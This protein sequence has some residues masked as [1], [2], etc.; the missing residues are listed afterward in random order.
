MWLLILFAINIRIEI[1]AL[2]FVFGTRQAN[3]YWLKTEKLNVMM[4]NAKFKELEQEIQS[5]KIQ[6]SALKSALDFE[7][8]ENKQQHQSLLAAKETAE[9]N[10]AHLRTLLRTIPDLIWLKD[11]EGI[12]LHLNTRFEEFFGA[13][14]SQIL[15][16]TDYDF[17]AKNLGDFFRENDKKAMLAGK[18]TKNEEL[19]RFAS[20]GHEEF[21]ETIK[22]PIFDK[23]GKLIGILGIGRNITE[24]IQMEKELLHLNADKDR[25]MQILAHDL[26]SPFTALLGFSELLLSNLRNYSLEDIESQ[27]LIIRNTSKKT[28]HLLEDILLWSKSQSGKLPFN[29]QKHDFSLVCQEIIEEKLNQALLKN[30]SITLSQSDPVTVFSDKSMLST[31]LRNLLSNAIKF[32]PQ[33][34][35]ISIQCETNGDMATIIVSDDGVGISADIQAKIWDFSNPFTTKGTEKEHGSGFGLSL[36]KEFVEKHGGKIWVE[37]KHSKGSDFKFTMP[38]S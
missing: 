25:F 3:K 14:E 37:S 34:G 6:N 18:P 12:Y 38:L 31:I 5:L 1:L 19:I 11:E 33:N 10:E 21:L 27:L 13:E 23:N 8:S 9:A 16:K 20:D 28:F 2:S 30:I 29:P 7:K 35:S 17:V 24:R 36:C 26:R 4:E 22:T 15:G 32:T